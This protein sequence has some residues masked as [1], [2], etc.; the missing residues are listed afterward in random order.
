[1]TLKERI[2]AGA[3]ITIALVAIG[4]VF[5]GNQRPVH[6]DVV[7]NGGDIAQS[8]FC[9]LDGV[10][11]TNVFNVSGCGQTPTTGSFT[12]TKD[13]SGGD[14]S[15][16][17]FSIHVKNDGT[18]VGGSPQ[19][20]SSSGTTYGSLSAGSYVVS[21]S[22]G[23]ANYTAA[24]S[25]GCDNNG[26]VAVA[27]NQNATCT[28]TNTYVPPV[29]TPTTG[30]L[31]VLKKF[32]GDV[33]VSPSLFSFD[34]GTASA[35]TSSVAWNSNGENDLILAPGTY[36]IVEDA[37]SSYM[38]SYDGCSAVSITAGATTTCTVTNTYVPPTPPSCTIVSDTNTQD[39]TDSHPAVLVSPI[40]AAWTATSNPIAFDPSAAW[41]WSENPAINTD[42]NTT[43]VFTRTFNIVG[44]P[45]AGSIDIG[46]DNGFVLKVNGTTV[47]DD[48]AIA[49]NFGASQHFDITSDLVSGS[50]TVEVD[51]TNFGV[52]GSDGSSNPA[53]VVFQV[54]I[55]Q[56]ACTTV[57][58]PPP[59][60][61]DVGVT[62]VADNTTPNIGATVTYTITATD[63][64]S[65]A[66]NVVIHD[67]LPSGLTFVS[68]STADT[69]GVYSTS[70][71]DWTI[72]S[73]TSETPA[74]LHI[75]ATVNSGLDNGTIITN[76]ATVTAGDT[77][78]D[79]ENNSA[80]AP[81]TVTI[82][83]TNGGGG[84]TTPTT[85]GGGGGNG[86]VVGSYGGG[87]NGPIVPN[88][89]VL[90]ASTSTMPNSC[91]QYLTAFIKFGQKNDASQVT[92]LQTFLNTYEGDHL[93]VNGIYDAATLAA[94][95]AFQQ[96]YGTDVLGP[97]GIKSPTGFVYLTTRKEVNE[98]YCHFTQ[99]FPL[100]ASEQAIINA[101]HNG[102]G[103]GS[104]AGGDH[105]STTT[106]PKNTV[107]TGTGS[108]EQTA[109][110]GVIM[111][112]N[113]TSSGVTG[114]SSP[115]SNPLNGI[116][117]FFKHLFGH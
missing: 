56:N 94:T 35:T 15:A 89:Q 24:F 66:T 85:S 1:M 4:F 21:E 64:G 104:T 44:A 23:P 32:S 102:T 110:V 91:T 36:S 3:I 8:I 19:P 107:T 117:S 70:T 2:R 52:A 79:S 51:V 9:I 10:P 76:T 22:G 46:A 97:W 98:I 50:N 18:D 68:T 6:A 83:S 5:L 112:T 48:S 59:T 65:D 101:A 47:V 78:E 54:N 84:G 116:G 75:L 60:P 90:G 73:L 81:I 53:G 45:V 111:D 41:I 96:K 40:N 58:P 43:K 12:V 30:G 29:V 20:G 17:D 7:P 37:T 100:S 33:S 63:T 39:V 13:V 67:V 93:T 82:P 80:P 71:G 115:V 26:N 34:Y 31:I 38:P 77:S 25:G 103:G 11:V 87:G 95:E 14:A 16:S 57:T 114:T 69:V 74:V 28:I 99:N 55:P 109:A 106:V 72:S 49:N 108:S 105:S 62:K 27:A 113:G 61:S 42:V 88:G 86:P 92:R